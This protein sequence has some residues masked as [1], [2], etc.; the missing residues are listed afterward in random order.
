MIPIRSFAVFGDPVEVL[1]PSDQTGGLSATLTQTSPPGGGPPPHSH[2]NEDETFFVLEGEYEIS[3]NGAVHKLSAGEAIHATRGSIH[4]FRNV[5]SK[6]GK[7]LVHIVPGGL[8]NYLEEISHFSIPEGMPQV[9]E[10]SERYGITF[11]S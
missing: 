6:D 3:L 9:L 2:Q 1:I 11:V 5:G 7:I 10:I 4:T 8:E